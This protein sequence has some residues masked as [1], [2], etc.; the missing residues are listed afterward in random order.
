MLQ[1]KGLVGDDAAWQGLVGRYGGNPLALSLVG[2]AIIDL[3]GGAI[4]ALLA[5]AVETVGAVF[6]GLRR[7]LEEQFVRLSALEQSVLYWLAVEREPVRAAALRADLGPV[8]GPG[9]V[10]EALEALGQ[11][12]LLE[13]GAERATH[14]LQPVV[15]EY[16]SERLVDVLAQEIVA[17]AP[18]LLR[19]HAVVQATN[20]D[21]VRRSQERLL[22]GP[23]LERVV[24]RCGGVAGAERRLGE[25]LQ[26]WRG[27]PRAEQGYGPG[28]VVNLLRLLRSNLRGLDLSHLFIRQVYLQEVDAQDVSLAGSHLSE[29]ALADAFD[30]CVPVSFS[31]D[32]RCLAA[33]TH[34]G[35]V[36]VWQL[37]DRT[38]IVSTQ[39]HKGGVHGIEWAGD[40]RLL[41]TGGFDGT[42]KLWEAQTG[43]LLAT[44]EGHTGLVR[45]VCFSKDGYLIAS[46]SLDA[47]V[48]LWE[49]STG[50][51]LHTLQGHEG[52][53]GVS[54]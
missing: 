32:G 2:Q 16:V 40:G 46:S 7:L 10:L 17:G 22:A 25:L 11:R 5:Y 51:P 15:L 13:R 6:G 30:F 14:T 50:Q 28:N 48:K 54:P 27:R 4:E 24:A 8:A 43:Q 26:G 1:G 29:C 44:L 12:S 41:A 35:E 42:V 9:A 18:G 53:C 19:S 49:T 33:G 52:G 21:Y 45:N 3:F 38:R 31:A 20:K 39:G 47:T 36:C 34:S 23:L 37:A